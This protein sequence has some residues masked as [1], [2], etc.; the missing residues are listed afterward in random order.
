VGKPGTGL[1][2]FGEAHSIAVSPRGELY[3]ADSAT[4]ALIKFVKR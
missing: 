1:G 4:G 2:E 3:V